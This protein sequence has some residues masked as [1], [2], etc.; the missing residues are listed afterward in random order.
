VFS[1]WVIS[2]VRGDFSHQTAPVAPHICPLKLDPVGTL[3]APFN[4]SPKDRDLTLKTEI[5]FTA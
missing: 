4:R 1:R 5:F 2:P 3:C